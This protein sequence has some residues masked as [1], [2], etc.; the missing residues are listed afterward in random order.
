MFRSPRRFLF[1]FP[2][3][4]PALMVMAG[5]WLAAV[6]GASAFSPGEP[7]RANQG[8]NVRSTAAGSVIGT[9]STGDTG[10]VIGGPVTAAIGG[11]STYVW[12]QID[13]NTG[14]DGWSF[15]NGLASGTP[16]NQNLV[17]G[18]DVSRYQGDISWPGVYAEGKRFAYCK[19]T[20]GMDYV[21]PKFAVNASGGRAAGM[22]MG[23]YHFARPANNPALVEAR[24]F[25][26]NLRPYLV[27]GNLRPVLD[28]ES[29]DTLGKSVLSAW[30]RTFCQEVE[31]LT[32]LRPFIYTSRNYA[33]NYLESDLAIYPLWIAVPNF[34]AGSSVVDI[35]PWADWTCQQYSWTGR[36]AGIGSS[37]V[38]TDLDAFRGTLADLAPWQIPA[39][40][41]SIT[42][43]ALTPAAS[44]RPAT[45]TISA[46][47][48]ATHARPVL[49]G[50]T[51]FPAGTGIGGTSHAAGEGP[52]TMA[53]GNTTLTRSFVLP[54]T[55]APGRYD[56]WLNL[57]VDVDAN[58]LINSGDTSLTGV[59]KKP[60]AL[61]VTAAPTF[62]SWAALQGLSG[63]NAGAG[64]D[65]DADGADNLT[66][67]AFSTHP[68][69]VT[70]GPRT[71]LTAQPDGSFAFSFARSTNRPDLT[72]TIQH[73]SDLASWS[74][75]AT[76]VGDAPF[77]NPGVEE[78]GTDPSQVKVTL[79]PG[80]D[81]TRFFRLKVHH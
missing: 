23:M 19:A 20:E 26:A 77:A 34:T 57:Y 15:E 80:T 1:L 47:V 67:Y 71:T 39:I 17:Y 2:F 53:A 7:V 24:W 32:L 18:I 74:D 59:F 55:L 63:P 52:F 45:L 60:D 41:Q 13:W 42:A 48:T 6:S 51:L 68:G 33:K 5:A 81:G 38:D 43:A 79:F 28:L 61:T 75:F 16:V 29:G 78:T 25:V 14:V 3:R 49:M 72:W 31:R 40:T 10:T 65:P 35:G 9:R 30:T 69:A 70:P 36:L 64:A 44:A 22:V 4:I 46:S 62:A 56:L 37:T 27:Q 12:W 73:A 54:P 21:D 11:G 50:A 66:E 76:T 58:G 8:V